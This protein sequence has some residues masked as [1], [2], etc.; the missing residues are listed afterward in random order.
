MRFRCILLM[1]YLDVAK[2]D[3]VLQSIYTYV[4]SVCFN[5]FKRML[6][7]FYLDIAYVGVAI[8]VCCNSQCFTRFIPMLLFHLDVAY[9]S[10]IC[11]K[12]LI[13]MLDLF[14]MYASL[15]IWMLQLLYIYICC[16]RVFVNVLL[17]SDVCCR[18]AF[19][20]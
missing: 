5:C 14:K 9:I 12:C 18:S 19:I 20:L 10:D 8:H 11:C 2:V 6:Q 3:L 7:V 17:V 16:K 4:A 15:F 13:K 1:F